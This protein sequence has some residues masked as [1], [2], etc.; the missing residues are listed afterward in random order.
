MTAAMLTITGLALAAWGLSASHRLPPRRAAFA[1]LAFPLGI[2]LF[3]SGALLL[4]VPGFLE[5]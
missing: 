1:S 5:K 3:L 4:A 2:A